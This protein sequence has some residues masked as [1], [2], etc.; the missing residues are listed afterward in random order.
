MKKAQDLGINTIILAAIGVLVLIILIAVFAGNMGKQNKNISSATNGAQS[1]TNV[2]ASSGVSTTE[3]SKA[4]TDAKNVDDCENVLIDKGLGGSLTCKLASRNPGGCWDSKVTSGS[5][6]FYI[7]NNGNSNSGQQ[8]A[9]DSSC[10]ESN[11]K[12]MFKSSDPY[13]YSKFTNE[14][15]TETTTDRLSWCNNKVN[16]YLKSECSGKLEC[17]AGG[18]HPSCQDTRVKTTDSNKEIYVCKK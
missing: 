10:D 13:T 9:T 12:N 6:T 2:M 16:S 7:C 15:K 17:V 5:S 18:S 14:L 1:V 8:A 3:L 4:L 11:I